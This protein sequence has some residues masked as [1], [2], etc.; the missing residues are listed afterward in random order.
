MGLVT[1]FIICCIV[2][3]VMGYYH[4][5]KDWREKIRKLRDRKNLPRL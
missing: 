2:F 5:R 4:A 1:W 3:Y